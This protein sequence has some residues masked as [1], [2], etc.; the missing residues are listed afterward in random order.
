[1]ASGAALLSQPTRNR[2]V[3]KQKEVDGIYFF[4][5]TLSYAFALLLLRIPLTFSSNVTFSQLSPLIFLGVLPSIYYGHQLL[6]KGDAPENCN[7][8]I[9]GTIISVFAHFLTLVALILGAF[10][11]VAALF[12]ALMNWNF[13]M[14]GTA[15]SNGLLLV[16]AIFLIVAWRVAGWWGL[17]RWILSCIASGCIRGIVPKWILREQPAV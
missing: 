4:L 12:G 5:G 10:T 14:A 7:A 1:M 13:I 9:G 6:T 11:A 3:I 17:D 2:E 8:K 16:L 15:S